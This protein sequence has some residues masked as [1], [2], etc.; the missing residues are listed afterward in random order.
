MN[1][2]P[3]TH[4]ADIATAA[5]GTIK[6]FQKHRIDFCCGG[7]LPLAE[8]CE[9]HQLD[10]QQIISELDGSLIAAEA[11]TDWTRAPLT[12]L[13]GH[14]Q[15]RF[16]RPLTAELPRLRAMLDKVVT[17]HGAR[18]PDTLP[19]LQNVFGE[20]MSELLSHMTKEDLVL[21][22]AIVS[23][24]AG[25]PPRAGGDWSWID[26]PIAAMEAEHAYAG[27]A[28]ERIAELTDGYA[29]PED[30]CPT[31][32]GLYHGLAELERDMHQHVHLENH[33]LFPR[34]AALARRVAVPEGEPW[35]ANH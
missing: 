2:T 5:P 33:I 12:D 16:H 29:P 23:L 20:L 9:R 28:L 35:T 11:T 22:P 8:V 30:A 18:L 3:S 34:A 24:E 7:K 31:F 14:I 15:R 13:I 21:F 1:I 26:Q 19:V 25:Q 32:R 17:R 6:V 4:V 10:L 27:A